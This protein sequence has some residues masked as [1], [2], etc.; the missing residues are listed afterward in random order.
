[1]TE[2]GGRRESHSAPPSL[3]EGPPGIPIAPIHRLPLEIRDIICDFMPV[4]SVLALRQT[5][6][7]FAAYGSSESPEEL[8]KQARAD[9]SGEERFSLVCF[10]ERDAWYG[11][12]SHGDMPLACRACMMCHPPVW[13]NR[14]MRSVVPDQRRCR[15]AM[16]CAHAGIS[17]TRYRKLRRATLASPSRRLLVLFPDS[18]GR[19]APGPVPNHDASMMTPSLTWSCHCVSWEKEGRDTVVLVSDFMVPASPLNMHY[20][21]LRL[22]F[23]PYQPASAIVL[24]SHVFC[25]HLSLRVILEGLLTIEGTIRPGPDTFVTC[26]VCRAKMFA[27]QYHHDHA[28]QWLLLRCKKNLGHGTQALDRTWLQNCGEV[29]F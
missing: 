22:S 13:F 10:R 4:S 26:E 11:Q 20:L 8:Y 21:G 9:V 16:I 17:L 12:A 18:Q 1:M 27:V 24:D 29:S 25:P 5:N 28:Y 3:P 15:T 23:N 14:P 2:E 19:V 7:F 6:R